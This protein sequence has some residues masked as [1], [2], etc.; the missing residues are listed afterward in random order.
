MAKDMA[1]LRF[2]SPLIDLE[3]QAEKI[4]DILYH[5]TNPAGVDGIFK[6]KSVWLSHSGF[7]NDSSEYEHTLKYVVDEIRRS[8]EKGALQFD[9]R[10]ALLDALYNSLF[11]MNITFLY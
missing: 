11:G 8:L 10:K 7:L 5:Y 9:S 4:P 6:S 1:M 2:S 3:K